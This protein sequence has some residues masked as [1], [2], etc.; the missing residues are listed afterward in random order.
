MQKTKKGERDYKKINR[1]LDSMGTCEITQIMQ[2]DRYWARA[3]LYIELIFNPKLTFI[4]NAEMWLRLSTFQ[5]GQ[6][7]GIYGYRNNVYSY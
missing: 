3:P 7:L 6:S 2:W 5:L 1:L 4:V